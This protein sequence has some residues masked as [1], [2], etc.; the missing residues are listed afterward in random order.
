[1]KISTAILM[2]IMILGVG[3][4]AFWGVSMYVLVKDSIYDYLEQDMD[5]RLDF[6]KNL[7]SFY[8]DKVEAGIISKEEAQKEVAT[9]ICG[10]MQANDTRDIMQ[11]LHKGSG[12]LN[13]WEPS[14]GTCIIHPFFEDKKVENLT[15]NMRDLI[16]RT[17]KGEERFEYTWEGVKKIDKAIYSR[18]LDVCFYQT[19]T[20][21]EFLT[22]TK[23]VRGYAL[24]MG[25]LVII[26]SFIFS[27]FITNKISRPIVDLV[28]ITDLVAGGDLTKQAPVYGHAELK[29][30][31]ESFNTM[32]SSLKSMI[33]LV[34][35]NSKELEE[36]SIVIASTSSQAAKVSIHLTG[37]TEEIANSSIRQS[38]SM[39]EVA[40]NIGKI[41]EFAIFAGKKAKEGKALIEKG[42][43]SV[44]KI[45]ADVDK[46]KKSIDEMLAKI[47]NLIPFISPVAE[48]IIDISGLAL[49]NSDACRD[50][51]K[52]I[53]NLSTNI[54]E[55]EKTAES[56]SVLATK[57]KDS[58]RKFEV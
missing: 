21:D 52:R 38:D 31:G 44:H 55:I 58:L 25:T 41:E 26:I 2:A 9:I 33:S 12:Y 29:R 16:D 22:P 13:A 4:T 11:G 54:E 24:G 45:L 39:E 42:I 14:T 36:S 56:L 50:T 15:P 3:I 53:E 48:S 7:Y 57:L 34:L 17:A 37:V 19:A 40:Q 8:L 6:S 32:I 10:E 46:L 20:L 35:A 1:M 47:D 28:E 5:E 30:L 43:G 49:K 18:E 27:L 23:I 51:F